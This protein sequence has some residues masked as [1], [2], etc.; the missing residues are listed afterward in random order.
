MWLYILNV[1]TIIIYAFLIKDKKKFVILVAIQLFLML[2]LRDVTMGVDMDN[3]MGG[4]NYISKMDFGGLMSS[5]KPSGV[6]ELVYPYYYEN[7][8]TILNWIASHIG[9]GFHGLLV[10]CAGIN[11]ASVSYFIYKYSKNPWFSFVIFCTFGFFIYDFGILRQSLALSMVIWAYVLADRRKLFFTIL[12]FLLALSFH[13]A[14]IIALPILGLLYFRVKLITK[15]GLLYLLIFTIPIIVFSN[16]IYGNII[17]NVMSAMD[18]LYI[19]HENGLNKR[20]FLLFGMAIFML[21]T[22]DFS[23]IKTKIDS[24]SC[25]ALMFSLYFSIFGLH[26]EALNRASQFLSIFLVILVP[27]VLDQYRGQKSKLLIELSISLLLMVYMCSNLEDSV[28]VPY[29]LYQGG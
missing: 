18:K 25:Y 2:A 1:I 24:V 11:I 6:S 20:I 9:I 12:S 7:G 13:R 29:V 15:K 28:I 22:Y 27:N 8:Y 26:N 17:A 5:L 3:Y 14:A 10:I 19:A 16:F 4:Y 23:K 21:F